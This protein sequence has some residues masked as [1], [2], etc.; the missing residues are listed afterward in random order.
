MATSGREWGK[1]QLQRSKWALRRWRTRRWNRE[2][3]TTRLLL[4]GWTKANT[5]IAVTPLAMELE[6]VANGI[7]KGVANAAKGVANA[8]GAASWQQSATPTALTVQWT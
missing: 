1:W 5:L 6:M 8:T 7:A 3:W 2:A 4:W